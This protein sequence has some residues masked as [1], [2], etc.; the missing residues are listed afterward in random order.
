MRRPSM[1]SIAAGSTPAPMIADVAAPAASVLSKPASRVRTACGLRTSRTV[2]SVPPP[3]APPPGRPLGPD[4]RPGGV[5]PGGARP[6]GAE[7]LD[8]ALRRH[9]LDREDVVGGEA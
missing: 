5:V 4:D 6:P 1:I 8:V 2:A 9:Q 3:R 7:P